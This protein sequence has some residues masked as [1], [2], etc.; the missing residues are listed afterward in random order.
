VD[1]FWYGVDFPGDTLTQVIITRI[2]FPSPADPLQAARKKSR[3][4]EEYW[5]RYRYDSDLKMKQ[6]IGRLIR[7]DTDRGTVIILDS[8]FTAA[9][10]ARILD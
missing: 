3:S 10:R 9:A 4:P 7:C 2:P 1:T 5:K 6:G 8:R